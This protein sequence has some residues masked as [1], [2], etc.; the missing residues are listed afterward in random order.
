MLRKVRTMRAA[1]LGGLADAPRVGL[2][3]ALPGRLLLQQA[4]RPITMASGLFS[5]CATPASRLP[6]AVSFSLWRSASRWRS[7]SR[8][9]FWRSVRSTIEAV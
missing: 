4:A 3:R 2:D 9:A 5:S 8:A 7:I 6:I 1:A